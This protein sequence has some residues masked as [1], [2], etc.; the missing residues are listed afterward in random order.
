MIDNPFNERDFEEDKLS[1]LDIK[2]QGQSGSIYDIEMQ[3]QVHAGLLKR[4]VFYG[5]ELYAG[6]LVGAMTIRSSSLLIRFAWSN[7]TGFGVTASKSTMRFVDRPHVWTRVGWNAG[8][9]LG[10][11]GLL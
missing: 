10:A 5:C 11:I 1:I 6:Q 9:S 3:L 2:A 7:V 8:N 4:I